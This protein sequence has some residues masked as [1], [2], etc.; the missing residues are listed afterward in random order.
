MSHIGLYSSKSGTFYLRNS[1]TSGFADT[2]FIYGPAATNPQ[3]IPITGDWTGQGIKTVGLF[4]PKTSTFHLRNSNTSGFADIT[5]TYG[6]AA[7]NP[8]WIP[9]TGDWTGQGITTVGLFD[10]KTATFY[11]R[12]SNTS[13]FADITFTYGPAATNP[14]WIP[15]TGDWTGQGITTV[16]LFDPKT[17]TFYLRNSNT[18]GF[19]D[20]KFTYGAA[21]ANPPWIPITGEW[22]GYGITKIGIYDPNSS[23]FHLR[24]SNTTGSC[25]DTA[26]VYGAPSN[27][28][29]ITGNW[30]NN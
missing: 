21:A 6:P 25:S 3:W 11:L 10:P 7:T 9:I 12:N 14:Q 2:T 5:F 8:Q 4:D 26:F 1:N 18:S 24:S 23:T 29:P 30:N 19:A 15:I 22:D 17:A 16:G 27:F 20:I 28:T 13:G